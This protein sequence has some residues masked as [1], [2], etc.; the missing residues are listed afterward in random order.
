MPLTASGHRHLLLAG[1]TLALLLPACRK[2]KTNTDPNPCLTQKANPLTFRVLERTGTPSPDTV[3]SNQDVA[4]EAPGAP[5]TSYQ[6]LIGSSPTVYMTKRVALFFPSSVEGQRQVR[7]IARRP[8]NTACFPKDDGVDTL[9]RIVTFVPRRT[10]IRTGLDRAAIIGRFQGAATDAPRDTFTIRIY[11][12][13]EPSGPAGDPRVP[14]TTMMSN[15]SKGCSSPYFE[16]SQSYYGISFNYGRNDFNC[17]T[18]IGGGYLATRDSI[19]ITYSRFAGPVG[20]ERVNKVFLGKR[21][22]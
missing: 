21:L 19:R 1:A 7:L 18:E 11:R 12:A 5:Y 16:V 20:F 9:A 10:D 17:L 2:D 13:P 6:W 8:P 22:R 14:W 3:Y 4:F 15:L